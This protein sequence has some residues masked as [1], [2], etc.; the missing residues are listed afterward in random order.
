MTQ[1]GDAVALSAVDFGRCG[2]ATGAL[3]TVTVKDFRGGPAGWSVTGEVTDLTGPGGAIGADRLSWTPVCVAEEGSPSACT[4]VAAGATLAFT[5]NGTVTGGEFT[6]DA[7][8]S[9]DVPAF[10]APGGY[11]GVLTPTLS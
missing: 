8:L 3:R 6:V 10:T 5:A 7:G 11:A 4:A 2:A 9:L 1:A